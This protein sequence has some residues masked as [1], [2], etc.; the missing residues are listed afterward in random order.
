MSISPELTDELVRLRQRLELAWS[1]DT[2]AAGDYDPARPSAGQCAV[3][4]LVVADRYGGE[5]LRTLNC[6]ASHYF[7]RL[8]DGS[9]VDLTRDQFP[10]WAPGDVVV[11]ER[12]YLEGYPQTMIRYEFLTVA[13][14]AVEAEAP[15]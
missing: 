3:T 6:G 15:A 10:V 7:N 4:A 8:P 2:A 13:L 11:R 9:E 1:A 12:S 5:L 14:A